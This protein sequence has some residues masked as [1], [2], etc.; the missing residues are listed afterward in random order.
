MLDIYFLSS[1]SHRSCQFPESVS[2]SIFLSTLTHTHTL[3][4]TLP[5]K[6]SMQYERSC[7]LTKYRS[8][9]LWWSFDR[10]TRI[11]FNIKTSSF[12]KLV[13]LLQYIFYKQIRREG[14]DGCD[15]QV[16]VLLL[17]II[18]TYTH[19]LNQLLINLCLINGISESMMRSRQDQYVIKARKK[20]IKKYVDISGCEGMGKI[21]VS[22]HHSAHLHS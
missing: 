2:V 10:L 21:F 7:D 8:R 16:W 9:P 14:M 3:I 13:P 11:I 19:T 12:F 15:V 18:P 17:S 22:I 6:L 4:V 1:L 20:D 5:F